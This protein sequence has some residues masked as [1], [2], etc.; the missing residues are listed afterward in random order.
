[1]VFSGFVAGPVYDLG[2]SRQ[3]LWL[4]SLL[5]VAGTVSQSFSHNLWQL[6]LSQ[7]V[8]IGIG[9]GCLAILGV[10]LP[11]LWFSK[12]LPLA[13]GIAASGSGVGG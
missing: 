5:I 12:R 4:G 9:M 13:N 11:S 10:A 6:L 8:C 3:Q 2:Y 1:M 7:G